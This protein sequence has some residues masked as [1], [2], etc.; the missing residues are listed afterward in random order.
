M[1]F[2][3][4][5]DDERLSGGRA[6][7]HD[8]PDDRATLLADD[9]LLLILDERTGRFPNKLPLNGVVSVAL[10]L[11]LASMGRLDVFGDEHRI[12]V[13]DAAP[14]GQPVLDAILAKLKQDEGALPRNALAMFAKGCFEQAVRRL[15]DGGLLR[16][17]QSS[18]MFGLVRGKTTWWHTSQERISLLRNELDDVLVTNREPDVRM[19]TL[20]SMLVV[21]TLLDRVLHA[22]DSE[23]VT[24][25]AERIAEDAG[26]ANAVTHAILDR[27]DA[28][29][30]RW[31]LYQEAG[32]GPLY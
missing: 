3:I 30:Q 20:I 10:L 18:R 1:I 28:M 2:A 32:P 11:E 5:V 26:V 16:E 24:S 22:A 12:F 6:M 13:E 31:A 17:E 8:D 14:T 27:S 15:I 25:R 9:L 7:D 4:L 19:A 29:L 21:L 23:Q